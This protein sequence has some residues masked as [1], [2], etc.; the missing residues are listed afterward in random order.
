VWQK[1]K[2]KADGTPT[3]FLFASALDF[4]C[5][6]SGKIGK[7]SGDTPA[8]GTLKVSCQGAIHE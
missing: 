7:Y 5:A 8:K 2:K 1:I 4:G 3:G 6:G